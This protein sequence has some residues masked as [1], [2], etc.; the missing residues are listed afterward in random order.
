V[1]SIAMPVALIALVTLAVV[2]LRHRLAPSWA[3]VASLATIPMAVLAG[4]LTEAGWAVP[5]PPAWI[6]L[7]LAAYGPA[8]ARR[9]VPADRVRRG[10]AAT[11][12]RS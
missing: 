4:V 3:P 11:S 2:V 7:G 9:T 8:L 10:L 12:P 6:F 1:A 5:H